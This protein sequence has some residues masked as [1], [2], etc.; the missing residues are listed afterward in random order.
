MTVRELRERVTAPTRRRSRA[1]GETL[2]ADLAARAGANV[3]PG[4]F[5]TTLV[6]G[7]LVAEVRVHIYRRPPATEALE[8]REAAL[9]RIRAELF[10]IER[11]CADVPSR[12]R[13]LSKTTRCSSPPVAVVVYQ[14]GWEHST[15]FPL[16]R[17]FLVVCAVHARKPPLEDPTRVLGTVALTE[18]ER[19][20][21][22]QLRSEEDRRERE[23]AAL[24]E[25]LCHELGLSE[26]VGRYGRAW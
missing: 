14:T 8:L 23:A 9:A 19:R 26:E 7:D 4:D 3:Q 17:A 5:E 18:G 15:T 12:G 22:R 20:E 21:L 13:S 10:R 2:L 11:C 25:D 1:S 6:D 24:R 16:T